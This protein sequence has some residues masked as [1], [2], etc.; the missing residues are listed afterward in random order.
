M[1]IGATSSFRS[2]NRFRE[3]VTDHLGHEPPHGLLVGR[4]QLIEEARRHQR[5][6]RRITG[7]GLVAVLGIGGSIVGLS[8]DGAHEHGGT[9]GTAASVT[10]PAQTAEGQSLPSATETSSPPTWESVLATQR[11][12]ALQAAH[13]A[14]AA[15]AAAA[16]KAEA[17]GNIRSSPQGGLLPAQA[18]AQA[19]I[20]EAEAAAA[21]AAATAAQSERR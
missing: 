11:A 9:V 2:S 4:P 10:A 7:A 12:A 3:L 1:G 19:A 8:L 21:A 15:A 13:N 16:E 17:D 14:A 20:A 5:R 6:R 18:A